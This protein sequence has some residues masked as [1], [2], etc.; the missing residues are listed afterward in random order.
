VADLNNYCIQC[1]TG[2]Y[3]SQGD[4]LKANQLCKTYDVNN[5]YCTSC[6]D[7]Y[8]LASNNC[9]SLSQVIIQDPNCLLFSGSLCIECKNRFYLNSS[10]SQLKCSAVNSMCDKYDMLTG[11]CFTCNLGSYLN[12]TSCL[13]TTNSSYVENSSLNCSLYDSLKNICVACYN[14]F[15]Y[16]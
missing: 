15:Y 7:G 8:Q 2:Y 4:C 10:S 6:Y 16:N 9:T 1:P 3:I 11:N 12:G 13:S 5:G 14:G